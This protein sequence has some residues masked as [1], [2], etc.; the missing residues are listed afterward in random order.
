M[1]NMKK[2]ICTLLMLTCMFSLTA[3][4]GEKKVLSYDAA[5]IKAQCSDMYDMVV[6][7]SN[8]DALAELATYNMYDLQNYSDI[9]YAE[10]GIRISGETAVAAAESYKNAIPEMGNISA[11]GEILFDAKEDEL[12]VTYK[13]DGSDHD[14]SIEIIYD[15]N[16]TVTSVTTNIEYSFEELMTKAGVNTA[17]GMGTVFVML[18]VIMIIITLLGFVPKIFEKKPKEEPK[19]DGVD[20]AIEGIVAREEAEADESDDLE[21]VAVIAAAIASYEGTSTD[22]FVVRSIKRIK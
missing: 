16:L 5:N 6:T 15:K 21:L 7:N 2:F 1:K 12:I 20:K 13:L 19:K 9:L 18:I 4:N 22:G 3:C 8:E 17:I 11:T 10:H 14:G